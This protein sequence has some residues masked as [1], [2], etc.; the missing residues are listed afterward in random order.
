MK[1]RITF[2]HLPAGGKTTRG[3][4]HYVTYNTK[5]SYQAEGNKHRNY[6]LPKWLWDRI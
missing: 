5:G 6:W 2:K 3:K 1:I 4:R